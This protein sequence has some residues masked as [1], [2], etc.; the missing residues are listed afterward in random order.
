MLFSYLQCHRLSLNQC[1]QTI[2]HPSTLSI[3]LRL[4]QVN[5]SFKTSHI[6][7][8]LSHIILNSRESFIIS[9]LQ[10]SLLLC[11]HLHIPQIQSNTILLPT[12]NPLN[13]FLSHKFIICQ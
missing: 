8:H 7:H 1:S 4:F 12:Y 9:H 3:P 6:F 13:M 2:S 5:H 11:C 10:N